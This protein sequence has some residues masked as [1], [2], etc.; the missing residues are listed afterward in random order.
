MRIFS[1][2]VHTP[3]TNREIEILKWTA[4]GKT[5]QETSDILR[6]SIDTVNFHVKNAISKLKSANR[7]AAVVQAAMLGLLA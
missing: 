2:S 5:T 7:T 1:R 3:L 4:D 6:I